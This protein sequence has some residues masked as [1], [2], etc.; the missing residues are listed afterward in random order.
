MR[1]APDLFFDTPAAQRTLQ[2]L[3]HR[4]K[5]PWKPGTQ[6]PW[7]DIGR[8]LALQQEEFQLSPPKKKRGRPKGSYKKEFPPMEDRLVDAVIEYARKH[9]VD[10]YMVMGPFAR[11]VQDKGG[12]SGDAKSIA[13]R[14]RTNLRN[15]RRRA[16][17][18]L[19]AA[20]MGPAPGP[21]KSD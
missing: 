2:R 20:L 21:K 5:I 7:E 19:I 6:V 14:F 18:D 15:R 16:D 9:D 1:S 12:L 8:L 11:V 10:P 4:L 17:E 13:K 3:C